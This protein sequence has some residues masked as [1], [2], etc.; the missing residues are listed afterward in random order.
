VDKSMRV[1]VG[2]QNL[3]DTQPPFSNQDQYFLA[4]YDPT[5]TDPRGRTFYASLSYSFR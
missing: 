2:I 4:T 3:L 5:Y 1:R